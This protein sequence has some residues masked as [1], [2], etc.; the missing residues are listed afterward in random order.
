MSRLALRPLWAIYKETLT[1]HGVRR[2]REF[3]LAQ[4]SFYEGANTLVLLLEHMLKQGNLEQL[5]KTIQGHADHL[6]AMYGERPRSRTG[7]N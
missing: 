2:K 3:R 4:V 7:R 5:H 6:H 1:E